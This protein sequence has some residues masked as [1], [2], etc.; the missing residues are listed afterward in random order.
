[1]PVFRTQAQIRQV[2][3]LTPTCLGK[4]LFTKPLNLRPI[5][6]AANGKATLIVQQSAEQNK[7]VCRFLRGRLLDNPGAIER[8]IVVPT[9][10]CAFE[11]KKSSQ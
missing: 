10:R 9:N 8:I 11:A 7:V 2:F 1:M 5:D 3:S 4:P 6:D